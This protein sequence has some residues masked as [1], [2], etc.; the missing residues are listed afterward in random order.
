MPKHKIIADTVEWGRVCITGRSWI[1]GHFLIERDNESFRFALAHVTI[2]QL[3]KK[4][5]ESISTK[6]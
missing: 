2:E 1:K 5:H 4:M 3:W 6:V